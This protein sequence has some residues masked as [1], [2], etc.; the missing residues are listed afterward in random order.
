MVLLLLIMIYP[1]YLTVIISVSDI[2]QVGLG[3]IYLWPSGL[4]IAAYRNVFNND[5][6]WIGYR[7][8]IIYTILGT[9]YSLALMLPLAYALSKK[10]LFGRTAISWYFMF[11]MF[12]SGGII[13]SYLLMRQLHLTNNPLIM[14]IGGVGIYNLIVTRTFFQNSIPNELYESAKMD[15]ASEFRC[16]FN[17][18]LPLSGAIIA[19]MAL[20]FSVARWNAYFDALIYLTD[21]RM[22]PL[23]LILRGILILNEQLVASREFFDF[24]REDQKRYLEL[25][26]MGEAM[27]YAVVFIASAPLLAAYPF[28]QK[29]FVK[30]VMIGSIKG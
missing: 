14:I 3:K 10:N 26:R 5:I 29:F 16:F 8:T 6:I 27:K 25:A 1:L 28:I 23:Q 18:A 20:Y 13:P 17:I 7:N 9:A 12:F 21:R 22:H 2:N 15:G 24:S 4:N 19:V 30:G 11:T